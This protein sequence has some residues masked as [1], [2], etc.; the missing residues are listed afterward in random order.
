[1]DG[2]CGQREAGQMGPRR[3]C[4]PE[5][6]PQQAGDAD[7]QGMGMSPT[8]QGRLVGWGL[9]VPTPTQEE[10]CLSRHPEWRQNPH[11][12]WLPSL[13]LSFSPRDSGGPVSDGVRIPELAHSRQSPEEGHWGSYRRQRG[14]GRCPW[15][16]TV[17]MHKVYTHTHCSDS[18]K[19]Q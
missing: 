6:S 7:G 4:K 8:D 10:A 3:R 11:L 19:A 9:Q 2:T 5:M 13:S 15:R 17:Y 1:M 12:T 14:Q 16:S 18:K